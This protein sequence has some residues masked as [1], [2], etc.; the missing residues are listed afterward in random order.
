MPGE[1]SSASATSARGGSEQAK[2]WRVAATTFRL[3]ILSRLCQTKAWNC[4]RGS[5]QTL[6]SRCRNLGMR[7]RAA[8]ALLGWFLLPGACLLS[9]MG[10]QER[11][12]KVQIDRLGG[13]G[14]GITSFWAPVFLSGMSPILSSIGLTYANLSSIGLF[15]PTGRV[16]PPRTDRLGRTGSVAPDRAVRPEVRDRGA[17]GDDGARSPSLKGRQTARGIAQGSPVSAVHRTRAGFV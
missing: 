11:V 10:D 5:Q 2:K 4:L 9:G 8:R 6:A 12:S 3:K 16:L 14:R 7:R 17:T 15:W 1:D 13:A